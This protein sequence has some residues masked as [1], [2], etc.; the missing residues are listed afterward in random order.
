MDNNDNSN[1]AHEQFDAYLAGTMS[2]SERKELEQR[3]ASDSELRAQLQSHTEFVAALQEVCGQ[4]DDQFERAMRNIADDDL[5]RLTHQ[6]KSDTSQERQA[7]QPAKGRVVPLSKVYRW[8]S[9]AAVVLLI[10]GVGGNMYYKSSS[11]AAM[12]DGIV[13]THT[14]EVGDIARNAGGD[15]EKAINLINEGQ[16]VKAITILEKIYKESATPGTPDNQLRPD[17]GETLAYAYV[18]NHDLKKAVKFIEEAKKE[19]GNE[20][21]EELKTLEKALEKIK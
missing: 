12:A 19:N 11:Q 4:A 17:I 20:T 10:A 3:L 7:H 13:A 21:P 15:Y 18:K 8:L 14:F 5:A 9:A 1:N 16:T 6:H 2:E